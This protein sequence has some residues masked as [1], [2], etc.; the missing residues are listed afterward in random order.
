MRAHTDP[1]GLELIETVRTPDRVIERS[2]G[3]SA[4][5]RVRPPGAGWFVL[6]DRERHTVWTRHTPVVR[7]TVRLKRR[8]LP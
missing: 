4:T 1:P 5:Y 2:D 6:R 3:R 7:S 8:W